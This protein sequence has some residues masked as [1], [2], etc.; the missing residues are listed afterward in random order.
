MKLKL[1]WPAEEGMRYDWR[2]FDSQIG[3]EIPVKLGGKTLT[4][5]VRE[6]EV[7][8]DGSYF[9]LTIEVVS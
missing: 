4:G 5:L 6:V 3:E 7:A 1:R 2:A 8:D 9:D